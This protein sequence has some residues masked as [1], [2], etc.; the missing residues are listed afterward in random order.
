MDKFTITF[1]QLKWTEH[2]PYLK[3]NLMSYL[4]VRCAISYHRDRTSSCSFFKD[5][6]RCTVDTL[7]RLRPSER[8][9]RGLE[10][11]LGCVYC[12]CVFLCCKPNSLRRS[13]T[14][15]SGIGTFRSYFWSGTGQIA[16]RVNFKK[17][18]YEFA[19]KIKDFYMNMCMYMYMLMYM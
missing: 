17:G 3:C 4:G 14:Y 18:N 5:C 7:C 12:V 8:L 13:L 6:I 2:N 11:H 9:D 1:T 19:I 10:S 16:E 15:V